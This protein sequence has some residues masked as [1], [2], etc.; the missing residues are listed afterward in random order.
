[1]NGELE[2]D[3]QIGREGKRVMREKIQGETAKFKGHLR[4][5]MET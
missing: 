1:M 4:D 3:D 5:S 2:W